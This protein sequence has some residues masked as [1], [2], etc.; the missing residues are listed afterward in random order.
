ME[1]K[2]MLKFK[3]SVIDLGEFGFSG[4]G[5]NLFLASKAVPV[6]VSEF[7]SRELLDAMDVFKHVF[8]WH[9]CDRANGRSGG[10]FS[11][12]SVRCQI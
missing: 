10:G 12:D 11:C 2:T 5:L 6:E 1:A 7:L 9:W 3:H 8:Q 4:D